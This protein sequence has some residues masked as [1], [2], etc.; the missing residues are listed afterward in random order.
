MIDGIVQFSIKW[1]LFVV[2]I[3]IALI[4]A[5]LYSATKLPIDAVPD[6]TT[7]QVQINTRAPAFTPLEIE[8]YVTIPVELA[9]SSLPRKQEIRSISKFGLSQVTVIFDDG[10][11]LYWA[12]QLILERLLEAQKDLPPDVSPELAPISTGLGEIY[13]FTVEDARDGKHHYSLMDLR[14]LLDWTIKPQLRT[15]PGVIEVNSFGGL[16]KQYEVLIDPAK[17][18]S[19]AIPLRDVFEALERNNSNAG[20]AYFEHRG[21]Q[22]LI[23]GVGLISNTSDIENIV[24]TARSGVPVYVRNIAQ[25]DIGSQI[26][27][28]AATKDGEGETVMGMAMLLKGENSRSVALRVG[29]KIR[30]IQKTLP[31]GVRIKTFLDRSDLV[32]QTIHTAARNL[33]EGGIFV[34][35]VLFLFLLQLRAG[36]IVS[37][38]IPLSMLCAII[39][40]HYFNISAN[41]MSLGAIDFGLIV[42]AAVIIVENC[43]RRLAE[44]RRVLDRKLTNEERLQIVGEGTLEVRRASQYG[45]III[46]AAYIPLISLAGIEGKMFRPMAFTVILALSGALLLSLTFVPALCA[47]FLRE[48]KTSRQRER[49]PIVD[50][51]QRLYEPALHLTVSSPRLTAVVALL[52]VAASAALV[53]LLGSEFLPKL[54]EGSIAINLVRLPSVSLTQAV[55]MTSAAEKAL[56]EFPEVQTVVSRLGSPE[57]ATDPM[58][59]DMG[60]TYVVLKPRA[61]WTSAKTKEELVNKMAERLESVPGMAYS[62]SQPVEFRMAELIEGIGSRSDIVVKVFGED[63]GVLQETGQRLAQILGNVA[64]AADV[65]AQETSGLPVLQIKIDRDRVGRY[66]IN[67]SDVQDVVRTAVAGTETTRILEGTKRFSLVARFIPS[68]RHDVD[69]LRNILVSG[70]NGSHIPLGQLATLSEEEGPSVVSRE[71][72]ERLTTVEA[73]VRGRDIGGFVPEAQA[74]VERELK[75]PP[76]YHLQWGGLWEHLESGRN[77]LL[78]AVPLTFFIVFLLLFTT[79]QSLRQAA[80]IFTGIPFALT[81]GVLSL[82]FRHMTFSMSAG[83]G[84][85]AVSGV[86]VLNGVVILAFFNQLR[87]KERNIKEAVM[88]GAITRLRPVL[89]TAFVASLGFV[90]MAISTSAG[91]EVQRP[92]ATVVIGGLVTSTLLTLLVLPALYRWVEERRSMNL[93]EKT[94]N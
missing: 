88:E 52:L 80:L 40:M 72:G 93:T 19:Y 50:F 2:L 41:L 73:N 9:M 29:E 39:G 3:T 58:G 45:E 13:Q 74:A 86:A 32:D 70:P 33:V 49:N 62:F 11:D 23:R 42:D 4:G 65:K 20:G 59:P 25:V 81:G 27:Q 31:P 91:A 75:L 83:V 53:P 14:T 30:E 77:R 6:V 28:G 64:G 57:I 24:V 76:G 61:E 35:L 12:R 34:M 66:G 43:V 54:D 48:P 79:F 69:S 1:R 63:L 92:L 68:A 8:Q 94:T 21:E 67:V 38:A 82:L 26:R 78:L 46:I 44:A 71:E 56:K 18:V 84:F 15:V 17:L 16:E 10:T 55:Q 89:M 22:Q 90:P 87:E 60:D 47:L 5:G 85:I 7:D 51:F 36:L 37:S